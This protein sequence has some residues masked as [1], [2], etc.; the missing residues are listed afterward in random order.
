MAEKTVA[1]SKLVLDSLDLT[2]NN[3]GKLLVDGM[4]QANSVDI[5]SVDTRVGEEEDNRSEDVASLDTRVGAEEDNRSEDVDSLDTRVG[6]EEDNR[7]EDVASLDTRVGAEEDNR[8]E[9]VDSLDTRV[10]EEEDNRSEDVASIDTRLAAEEKTTQVATLDLSSGAVSV[11]ITYASDLGMDTPFSSTPAVCA[12]MRNTSADADIIIP[13]LAGTPS[14]TACKFV[15][16]D[17]IS[18]GN[19]KLDIIVT[20]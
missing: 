7:S 8:S 16:S 5:H 6:E 10:G 20:D 11:E 14:T 9:D 12:N 18:G 1:V 15:F 19:Y 13:M 17:E 2:T 3:D 4:I